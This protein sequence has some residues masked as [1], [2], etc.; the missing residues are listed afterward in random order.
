[1]LDP[2]A[3]AAYRNRLTELRE[4]LADAERCN[5]IG[6]SERAR[7]EIE[8]IT[9]QLAAAVGLGGRDRTVASTAERARSTVSKR[10]KDAVKQIGT[11]HPPLADHMSRRVKTGVFCCYLPDD[12]LPIDWKLS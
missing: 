7:E 1:M 10:I 4:E 12:A 8:A 9:A 2:A 6:R 11:I 5:D 3:K